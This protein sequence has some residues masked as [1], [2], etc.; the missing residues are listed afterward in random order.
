MGFRFPVYER[1]LANLYK[2]EL[3]GNIIPFWLEHSQDKEFGGYFS[4]LQ[5]NGAVFDTDKFIWLQGREAWMFAMMYN[6]VEKRQE[7]LDCAIQ[8]AEFLKKHGHDETIVKAPVSDL[9]NSLAGR[10]PGLRVVTRSG[11]PGYNA[12]EIDVRGF[13]NALI[14]VDGV[15]SDFSQL[16]PNEIDNISVLKDASAAVYGV[17][18]ANGVVLVTTKKG[19]ESRTKINF[20]STFSWQRPTIYPDFVNA[21]QFAELTDEDTMNRGGTNFL[22]DPEELEKWRAGGP[23][24]EGTNW[25]KLVQR[26]YAPQQQYNLNIRGGTEKLKYFASLGYLTQDG[27][28]KSGANKFERYNVRSNV[29]AYITK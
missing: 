23:G 21:A 11:E 26:D 15:P 8:G 29:D 5:R 14:I 28:W 17:K 4:C 18:A 6:K 2:K 1:Y 7:W 27:M 16:D 9:S 3:L 20:N 25:K 24:Y 12:S 22:F 10:L 13:G 19:V